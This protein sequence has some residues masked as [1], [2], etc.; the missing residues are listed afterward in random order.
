MG[1]GDLPL[2][3][4]VITTVDAPDQSGRS[5]LHCIVA[6]NN[7]TDE[8]L[9]AIAEVLIDQL[10]AD[11]NLCT[12]ATQNVHWAAEKVSFADEKDVA[13]FMNPWIPHYPPVIYN[14]DSVS[15]VCQCNA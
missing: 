15:C 10:G 8:E 6:M 5:M 4:P 9:R 7:S 2:W 1:L 3:A 12:A 13:S 11:V 14:S